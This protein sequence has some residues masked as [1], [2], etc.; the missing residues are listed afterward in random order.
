MKCQ[1]CDSA[2]GLEAIRRDA[3]QI[4]KCAEFVVDENAERLKRSGRGMQFAVARG[5][6]EVRP[7]RP[8]HPLGSQNELCE[9]AGFLRR[10][11]FAHLHD[12][13][14]NFCR[15]GLVGVFAQHTL[16]FGLRQCGQPIGGRA[17]DS[18]VHAHVERA[19]VFIR[20]AARRIVDLHAGDAEIGEDRVAGGEGFAGENCGQAG[21]IAVKKAQ[22]VGRG[23]ALF[24]EAGARALELCAVD[25]E[26]DER[27]GGLDGAEKRG[28]VTAVAERAIGDDFSGIQMQCGTDS[29]EEDRHVCAGG[30]AALGANVLVHIG[31]AL[32]GVFL[33]A[34]VILARVS[35]GVALATLGRRWRTGCGFVGTGHAMI[36]A[37]SGGDRKC[38]GSRIPESGVARKRGRIPR[39]ARWRSQ[40]ERGKLYRD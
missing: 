13:L 20:E 40:W 3:Q 4:A 35:A 38:R 5:I 8:P 23:M 30:S 2:A 19:V 11:Y 15:I 32:G 29:V 34:L 37:K 7:A 36:V 9:V 21:E 22:G 31:E 25:V 17:G 33:I 18:R 26:A 14:C 24:G 6:V 39:R 16:Q 1:D 27:A 12:H 28:G 10:F